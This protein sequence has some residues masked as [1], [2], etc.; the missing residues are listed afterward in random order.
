MFEGEQRTWSKWVDAWNFQMEKDYAKIVATKVLGPREKLA[1]KRPLTKNQQVRVNRNVKK[2]TIK[3]PS[4]TYWDRILTNLQFHSEVG[5]I[6][7]ESF[8]TKLCGITASDMDFGLISGAVLTTTMVGL[9]AWSNTHWADKSISD[10][11]RQRDLHVTRLQG[12]YPFSP[13]SSRQHLI[14]LVAE[15]RACEFDRFSVWEKMLHGS[16]HPVLMKQDDMSF[17]SFVR[18][19]ETHF[20]GG[21]KAKRAIARQEARRMARA[22]RKRTNELAEAERYRAAMLE[23]I[24]D[25]AA[26]KIQRFVRSKNART[27]LRLIVEAAVLEAKKIK[28]AER[29]REAWSR[30]K[31][32]L[33]ARR[34][35][36]RLR[37]QKVSRDI[38][39]EERRLVHEMKMHRR[40]TALIGEWWNF[41]API[42]DMSE[43]EQ[44][45]RVA[46]HPDAICSPATMDRWGVTLDIMPKLWELMNRRTP[47]KQWEF[48]GCQGR[49]KECPSCTKF[50]Y[51]LVK[52]YQLKPCAHHRTYLVYYTVLA[53]INPHGDHGW[54]DKAKPSTWRNH[55]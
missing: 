26:T 16:Q 46:H 23:T 4:S 51:P 25:Q 40:R 49:N 18:L 3:L 34:E 22:E 6:R 48:S 53:L 42:A 27:K 13:D 45:L 21:K 32:C 37:A 19:V 39:E 36:A 1:R 15:L 47:Y 30:K 41:T 29:L 24:R 50:T 12:E 5:R 2:V 20:R 43:S 31:A 28:I 14:R 44:A 8:G 55:K 38:K 54:Q 17:A 9:L 10:L 7:M 11:R 33:P 35:L 52:G